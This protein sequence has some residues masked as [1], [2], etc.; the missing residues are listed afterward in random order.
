MPMYWS[1]HQYPTLRDRPRAERQ[2]VVQAA[3]KATR[4]K[5]GRRLFIVFVAVIAASIA[6]TTRV[7]PAMRL[8]N[9]RTWIAPVCGALF[10]YLYLLVEINGSIH[11][12]VKTYLADKNAAKH[13]KKK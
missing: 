2:A 4:A 8:D 10:I 1:I 3:L 6:A 12:A 9:W 13:P 11:N 5:F 7:S